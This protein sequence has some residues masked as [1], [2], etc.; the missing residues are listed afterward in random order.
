M[1]S[2][3][4]ATAN[5]HKVSEFAE[6]FAD[7]SIECAMHSSAEFENYESPEEDGDTFEKNAFIKAEALKKC[8]P[9]GAYVVADD[10]GIVVDALGGAPGIHSARYAGVSGRAADAANNAKLLNALENVAD[11]KRTARFVCAIALICPDGERVSFG[12]KIEGVINRGESGANGFG[13]DP[14]FFLPERACTTAEL[15]AA[16]KNEI[17]HRGRAFKKLAEFLRKKERL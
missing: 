8:V 3:Y 9:E 12:G 13:Y 15:S 7:S 11:K 10:S 14:L 1:F 17:S 6:M 2:I 5:P 4:L 16:D